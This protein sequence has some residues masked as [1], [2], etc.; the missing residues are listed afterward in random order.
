MI[1]ILLVEPDAVLARTYK[2][3]LKGAGFEVAVAHQA[4]SAIKLMD[5]KSPKLIILELQLAGHN[6]VELI[7]ELRSYPD[8]QNVPI[9][10]LTEVNQ[11]DSGVDKTAMGALNIAEY[12]Y[13]ATTSLADLTKAVS[14]VGYA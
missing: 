3:A 13:K 8:W 5:E 14:L 10:I 6:G 11:A 12:C 2:E 7:Y 1:D 9:I 4:Q